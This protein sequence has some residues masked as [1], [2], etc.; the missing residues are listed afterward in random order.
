MPRAALLSR[1]PLG[2]VLA[3]S[4]ASATACRPIAYAAH[5]VQLPHLFGARPRLQP[6]TAIAAG[7]AVLVGAGDIGFCGLAGDGATAALLDR[8][9]GT[10]ITL[11]DNAYPD[12]TVAD[13]DRCFAPTWGRHR[14][15]MHPTPGNH[16]WHG[17]ARS[18]GAGY[19][20]WFAR[21]VD[22]AIDS[23]I[24]Y[25]GEPGLGWYSWDAGRGDARWHVVALNSNLTGDEMAEQ[26]R[27][28]AGDL[29]A[30]PAACTLAYWH[31]SLFVSAKDSTPA[32]RPLWEALERAGA[33]VILSAHWH[34]YER[35]APMRASG[36]GDSTRG[37]RSFV[38]GTGGAGLDRFPRLAGLTGHHAPHSEKRDSRH[39]GVM[40]MELYPGRYVWEFIGVNG[41]IYDRGEGSCH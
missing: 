26:A 25:V 22:R 8:I 13:F 37:I 14:A 2:L 38:V 6:D 5:W 12:G 33:D 23:S 28:L 34:V 29:A 1:A 31:H 3:T 18:A 15:R 21:P 40:K 9:P 7:G 39:Y 17:G 32:V 11:G 24:T 36:A 35:L 10:V 27:W 16:E 20:T 19:F 41:R 4:L 30:H